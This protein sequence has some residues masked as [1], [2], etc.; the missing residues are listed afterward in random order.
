M[1]FLTSNYSVCARYTSCKGVWKQLKLKLVVTD[2]KS[3]VR[4]KEGEIGGKREKHVGFRKQTAFADDW[5]PSLWKPPVLP[6]FGILG[7][8]SH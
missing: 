3:R 7:Y 2:I 6:V 4:K 8:Q 5:I 1:S